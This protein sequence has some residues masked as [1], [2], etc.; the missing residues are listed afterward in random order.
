MQFY[1]G[2]A[3]N[4]WD[5]K[6]SNKI[7]NHWESPDWVIFYHINDIHISLKTCFKVSWFFLFVFFCLHFFLRCLCS[8][9]YGYLC[10]SYGIQNEFARPYLY[11]KCYVFVCIG[12]TIFL[13]FELPSELLW[14][15]RGFCCRF[16]SNAR[17]SWK[18]FDK[19]FHQSF[20]VHTGL[21]KNLKMKFQ[22]LGCMK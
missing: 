1:Q 12:N 6:T 20:M 4:S 19:I 9:F 15:T 18:Y 16:S 2:L 21:I 14:L 10:N 17:I 22:Q 11:S 3:W 13:M 8:H 5:F 7:R